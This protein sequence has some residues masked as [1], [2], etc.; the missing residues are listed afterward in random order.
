MVNLKRI[1][2]YVI[3]TMVALATIYFLFLIREVLFTFLFGTFLAYILFR[4][5]LF[6]E[7]QGIKRVWAILLIY[8]FLIVSIT[9]ALIFI[10][11][12]LV[13]ELGELAKIIPEY[14]DEAQDMAK[15]IENLAMPTKL[16]EIFQQNV[17][18]IET[19]IYSGLK[20]S[21]NVLYNMLGKVVALIFSPILA[22]YIVNDW[23]M[24]R[25][26]FLNF[27]SPSGRRELINLSEKL[28]TV[29]IEFL[30]GY[31]MVSTFVGVSIGLI[32]AILGVDFP[33]LLGLL[34]GITNFIPY[35]GAFLGGIPA[36]AVALSGS[37]K[38]A[39]YMTIGIFIVQQIE[40][41]L[42][43]P[44]LIGSKIGLHPLVI[45]FALLA[46]GKLFGIWGILLAVP[47]AAILKIVIGWLYLKL[48]EP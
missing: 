23:E 10:I 8:L 36:V 45:V 46:G 22:F 5:V 48:V 33:L 28:D 25:D 47:T 7:K 43:T 13:K 42:I 26:G 41:N 40:S 27:F 16:N 4:P 9:I 34:S 21:L 20:N 17:H 29:L 19:Y 15:R 30:K 31:L 24:M 3:F 38:L 37:F 18:K 32:A 2:R 6:I 14:A 1:T 12:S 11:P 44:N 39:I 35:F